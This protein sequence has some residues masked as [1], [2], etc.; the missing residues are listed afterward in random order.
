MNTRACQSLA[1]LSLL[2]SACENPPPPPPEVRYVKT[3]VV[4]ATTEASTSREYSGEVR[5]RYDAV[6]SFRVPGKIVARLVNAGAAV[7]AGQA[8]AKL[9]ASDAALQSVEAE[10]R[11]SLADADVKRY[12]DL[13]A[14][15]FIS[16]SA[17][18]AKETEF[19]AAEAQ[20]ALARNQASYTTL[21]A[22]QAGV[23]AEVLA[24]PGQVVAAGQGVFRLARDGERDVVIQL[25]ETVVSAVKLGDAVE[26]RLWTDTAHLYHGKVR[27]VAGAADP[28]TRTFVARI[29]INDADANVGLGM[30]ATAR[31]A[32][33]GADPIMIPIASIFQQGEHPAVWILDKNRTISLKQIE[34]ERYTD[35]G[36]VIK[37][38]LQEGDLIVAAGVHKL[39]TGEK[40]T[41]IESAHK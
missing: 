37:S 18:D 27:E 30:T 34:I 29:A 15:H 17:L 36:A 21:V 6:A 40:V 8:L 23:V 2:L 31:F 16:Q 28:A 4:H 9:D 5:A 41:P 13:R 19:K 32:H 39:A 38:G 20:A 11:R 24:E 14:K 25:P 7:K 1:L 10:A 12:R 33:S 22:D 35:E 3:F 26:L